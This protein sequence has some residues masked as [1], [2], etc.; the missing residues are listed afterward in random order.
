MGSNVVDN[1]RGLADFVQYD[2]SKPMNIVWELRTPIPAKF[3]KK[4]NQLAV[5]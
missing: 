2:G 5:G 1:S 4:T 3:L